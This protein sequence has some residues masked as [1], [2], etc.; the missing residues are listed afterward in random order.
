[1]VK[2]S[3][4]EIVQTLVWRSLSAQKCGAL[5][6]IDLW[7]NGKCRDR[8]ETLAER[9]PRGEVYCSTRGF[10]GALCLY[11]YACVSWTPKGVRKN[12]GPAITCELFGFRW[13]I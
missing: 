12:E 8:V 1:M 11:V 6:M 7:T 5:F 13:S 2:N 9:N 3:W 10:P 4:V